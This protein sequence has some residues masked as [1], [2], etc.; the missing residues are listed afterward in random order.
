MWLLILLAMTS[1][2]TKEEAVKLATEALVLE[3]GLEP[4]EV[5]V[6]RASPVD[7]PDESLGCPEPG[8]R[9]PQV[10]TSGYRVTLQARGEIHSVHVGAGRAVV[11]EGGMQAR[12]GASDRGSSV[13]A[14]LENAPAIPLPESPRLRELAMAARADLSRR[15][16]VKPEAIDLLEVEEV[17]WR[18]ASLGC[19]KPGRLYPQATR[20]GHRV[21]LRFGKRIYAYHSGAAGEPFLCENPSKG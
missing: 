12:P 15:L 11:C 7:W 19:P 6:R 4:L 21:R 5:E 3:T 10:V 17:V 16:E 8:E 9:Y 13:E 20:E 14:E 1:T 2:M 18:D